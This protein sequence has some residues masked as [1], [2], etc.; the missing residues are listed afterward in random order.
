MAVSKKSSGKDTLWLVLLAVTGVLTAVGVC[1]TALAHGLPQV[2][3]IGM[4]VLPL[5]AGCS[6]IVLLFASRF[7]W[8]LGAPLAAMVRAKFS[9]GRLGPAIAWLERGK[10]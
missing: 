2:T 4:G 6:V 8:F 9:T 3:A 10:N 5:L 7:A 1:V